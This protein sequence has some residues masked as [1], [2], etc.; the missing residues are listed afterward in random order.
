MSTQ[1]VVKLQVHVGKDHI[2]KL[3]SE[4]P[5]G[6]A[7]VIAIAGAQEERT[8]DLSGAALWAEVSDE[9][10][11]AFTDAMRRLRETDKLQTGS[12]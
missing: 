12:E 5:E 6:P 11:D 10:Y 9:E 2:V 1:R 7:E 8:T 4:F 3:P